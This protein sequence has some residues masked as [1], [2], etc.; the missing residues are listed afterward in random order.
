MERR[1]FVRTSVSSMRLGAAAIAVCAACLGGCS[2][3]HLSE[4]GELV[5]TMKPSF[6]PREW[7]MGQYEDLP[8]VWPTKR[9][10]REAWVEVTTITG[11]ILLV[12]VFVAAAILLGGCGC[13]S[14]EYHSGGFSGGYSSCR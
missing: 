4:R 13:V 2:S 14:G 5:T 10:A 9:E 8:D 11:Q 6:W 1:R 7:S 12:P 3:T